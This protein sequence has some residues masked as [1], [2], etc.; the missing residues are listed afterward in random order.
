MK[1]IQ[2]M[3]EEYI[4]APKEIKTMRLSWGYFIGGAVG[5]ILLGIFYWISTIIGD[6]IFLKLEKIFKIQ[7]HIFLIRWIIIFVVR[8]TLIGI[9]YFFFKT[10]LLGILAPFFS[11]ISEKVEGHIY[12]IEYNFSL[13]ENFKFILRG[14]KLAG[15]SFVKETVATIIII[16]LS[17]IPVINLLVPILIFL[18]QSYFISFNFVDYTLERKKYDSDKTFEFMK[19][20]RVVFTIGGGI[21][22]LLYLIPIVGIFVAPLI[23]IVAFTRVTLRLLEE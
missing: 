20:N 22:T 16:C 10:L 12:G 4:N 3:I 5:I 13:K 23:S 17:F 21:F 9:Y 14:I 1:N 18:V 19:K 6:W 11:Y 15:K 2:M 8:T 7:D